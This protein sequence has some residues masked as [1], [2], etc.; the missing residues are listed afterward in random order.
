[1]LARD[2]ERV[3]KLTTPLSV[4]ARWTSP[5]TIGAHDLFW[6]GVP[7]PRDRALDQALVGRP[8]LVF[9]HGR[10]KGIEKNLRPQRPPTEEAR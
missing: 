1:M 5:D 2:E 10:V 7:D 6:R 8:R 3:S 9:Q 4:F